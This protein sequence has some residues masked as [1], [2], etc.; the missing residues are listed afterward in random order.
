MV[1]TSWGEMQHGVRPA[2][3]RGVIVSGHSYQ[4]SQQAPRRRRG[5]RLMCLVVLG[6]IVGYLSQIG[7]GL[8][9]PRDPKQWKRGDWGKRSPSFLFRNTS[10]PAGPTLKT[11]GGPCPPIDSAL[12]N[13]P[14]LLIV[15]HVH[16][17]IALRMLRRIP[18]KRHQTLLLLLLLPRSAVRARPSPARTRRIRVHADISYR[19]ACCNFARQ[20][21][22]P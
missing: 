13:T 6:V 11:D 5:S 2:V 3:A 22:T 19:R 8:D 12:P 4:S 17:N 18:N 1:N 16:H 10:R 9:R 20:S 21:E 7:R 14:S 15:L